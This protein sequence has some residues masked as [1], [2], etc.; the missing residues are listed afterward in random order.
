M[1]KKE[2]GKEEEEEERRTQMPS[3]HKILKSIVSIGTA[4]VRAKVDAHDSCDLD[5]YFACNRQNW[6]ILKKTLL[7][8]LRAKRCKARVR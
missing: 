7:V 6:L 2:E 1:R 4:L 3:F 5:G 8:Q